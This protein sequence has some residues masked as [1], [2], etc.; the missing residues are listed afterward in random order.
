MLDMCMLN[1]KGAHSHLQKALVLQKRLKY[2]G[3]RG[4]PR[5]LMLA[6]ELR[7]AEGIEH[8]DDDHS[9]PSGKC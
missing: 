2:R 1:R 4:E 3:D 9:A 8:R 5:N 7:E 6:Q